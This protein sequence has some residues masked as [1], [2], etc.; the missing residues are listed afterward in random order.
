MDQTELRNWKTKGIA[1][2]WGV[3]MK[4]DFYVDV[5]N[6]NAI[7]V[8][9]MLKMPIL[10]FHGTDDM[11]VPISQAYEAKH[12]NP[13]IELSEISGGGHRFGDKMKP[14]EWEKRVEEFILKIINK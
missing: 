5:V 9:P 3:P 2:V 1:V 12:N 13:N 4:Y 8:N 11:V 7:K 10:W 14:G 6:L